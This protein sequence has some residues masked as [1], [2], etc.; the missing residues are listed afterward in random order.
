MTSTPLA[1]TQGDGSGSE[2][3]GLARVSAEQ[4]LEIER[5]H[6]VS[7]C[8]SLVHRYILIDNARKELPMNC[9]P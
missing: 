5:N 1:I 9:Q 2:T 4:L 8:Q 6:N 3:N 7:V